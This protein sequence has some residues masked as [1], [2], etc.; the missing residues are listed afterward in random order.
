[1]SCAVNTARERICERTLILSLH[2]ADQSH[3]PA[4]TL[5]DHLNSMTRFVADR[6]W[7]GRYGFRRAALPIVNN[8]ADAPDLHRGHQ[9]AH[10]L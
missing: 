9:S 4:T 2:A 3:K 8:G 1:M 6:P 7:L 10:Q 5:G